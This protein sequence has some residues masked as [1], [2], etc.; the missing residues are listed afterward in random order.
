MQMPYT[1]SCHVVL[2]YQLSEDHLYEWI[3]R[4]H[5]DKCK[6]KGPGPYCS[7]CGHPSDLTTKQKVPRNGVDLQRN[8]LLDIPILTFFVGK[9]AW[10]QQPR[11]VWTF[12][13]IL[14]EGGVENRV[15]AF[16]RVSFGTPVEI[17]NY[18]RTCR[19]YF[20]P[21]N[22]WNPERWGTWLAFRFG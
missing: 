16:D 9:E 4:N 13:S 3:E 18:E 21:L 8:T 22:L 11:R 12:A 15:K 19:N 6:N 2:G 17:S 10:D 5:H 7:F 1:A 14:F 20:E